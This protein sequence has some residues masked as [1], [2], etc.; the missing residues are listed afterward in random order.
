MT[1]PQGA[2]SDLPSSR[3]VEDVIMDPAAT[4]GRTLSAGDERLD[5]VLCELVDP[6]APPDYVALQAW[7]TPANDTWL[8]LQAMR[9]ALLRERKVATSEGFAPRL[10]PITGQLHKGGPAAGIF[11]QFVSDGGPDLPVPGQSYSFAR[12]K[13]AQS[14]ADLQALRA[15]G[16]RVL[17]VDVGPDAVAGLRAFR[18]RLERA[19][20]DSACS[21]ARAA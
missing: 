13:H 11:V 10:L 3:S 8:E 19:L 1:R 18:R 20:D 9:E 2:G 15:R 6:L 16:R 4:D 14:L 21:P 7:L 17:R 12:L 5:R